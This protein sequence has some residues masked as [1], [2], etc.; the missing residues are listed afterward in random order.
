M[1]LLDFKKLMILLWKNFTLKRRKCMALV[2]EILI[3]VMFGISL[4]G[5]RN[6]IILK[7]T[8]PFNYTAFPVNHKPSFIEAPVTFPYPW[9][10]AYIPSKSAVV[11]NIVENV[12]K[13]LNT[14]MKVVGFSSERDFE[15]Y[16]K[17]SK[18]SEKVLAAIVF[19]H[20][21]QNSN[22]AVPLKVKYYL[23]FSY[24]KKNKSVSQ[25]AGW[26]TN[27]L[28]PLLPLEP[29]DV[30]AADGGRPGYI[31]EGFL[32]VQHAL[33]KAIM[34]YHSGT[35]AE[36]LFN[37]VNIFVQRFPYPL[38]NTDLFFVIAAIIIPVIVAFVFSMNHLTLVQ[39]IVWEKENQLKEFQLMSGLSNWMLWT[40][41]FITFLF[42]YL[43][44]II[45]MCFIFFVKIEPAPVFQYSDPSLIF[46]FLLFYAIAIIFFS[47]M[48]STFFDKRAVFPGKYGMPKPWNFFLMRSYWARKQHATKGE[49][50]QYEKTVQSKYFE[51]EPT[52]L[53]A[54]IQIKH[55]HKV[56]QEN[57]T[58]KVAVKDLSLNLYEGQI[59][60]LL[61][62][63][64]AGKST[65][66]SI[67]SGLYP[68]TSGKAYINGYDISHDMNQIRKSFGVCP[69]KNLLFDYLTVSEHLYFYCMIKGVPHKMCLKEIGHMLSVFKLL[70]KQSAFSKSLSGGMKRKLSIIIA[71]IGGSKVVIVDEPTSGM[72]TASRRATWDLLQNY[73]QGRTILLTTHY[74][75]EADVLGDRIAI[76][77]NG[78]LKCCGSSMFLKHL[79]GVGYH[80]VMVKAPH[81]DV[82]EISKLIHH[83]AP[84]ATLESNV[85]TELSFI[86][87]KEYTDRFEDLFTT[88]ERRQDEL[89]IN[90]FGASVTT[91]EEVFLKVSH[92]ESQTDIQA[93]QSLSQ[94]SKVLT[95]RQNSNMSNNVKR[96]HSL[97]E[98]TT[99]FNTGS[100]RYCQ[101]F[102]AMLLKKLLFS[103]RNWKLIFLQIFG[104]LIPTILLF[105]DSDF[106]IADEE[107]S[108]QMNLDEYGQTIVPYSISGNSTL[109]ISLLKHLESMLAPKNHILREVQG[110]VVNYLRE[111]KECITMCIV[112]LS[113]EVRTN[114][115]IFTALFNNQAYHS[116]SLSLSVLDNI[117]FMSLSGAD[118]SITVY[119]KPQPP[120]KKTKIKQ[121]ERTMNGQE[122]AIKLQ[123]GIALLISGFC[124]LTV[125]ERITKSK[126]I[127][128]LCGVSTLV[129]W[130]SALL[131]DFIIFFI[132]CCLLLGI[133]KYHKIDIYVMDYHF[134]ET[135]LILTLYGWSSI[136]LIYL[137]SFLFSKSTSA[138]IKLVLFNY[139]SGTYSILIEQ[140][141][142]TKME[143][144][145]SNTTQA[146][147]RNMLLLLPNYNL[148]KC[149]SDYTEV[150]RVKILCTQKTVNYLLNCSK[151]N[152]E[153]SIYSLENH[154]IGKCLIAMSILG[155][156]FLIFIFLWENALWRLR[157]FIHQYIYFGIYKKFKKDLMSQ[158]LSGKSEDKDVQDERTRILEQ[159]EELLKSP[160][161]IKELVKIYFK[162]PVILA[163]KN[164]SLAVQKRECFGLLGFNGAGKTTT[165][166]ILT[167]E[168]SPTSGDVFIDGFN[169]TKNNLKVRS[170]IGYCPQFDALLDYMTGKEIITMYARVWGV[171]EHQ[172][173]LYVDKHLKSLE[174]EPH[175]NNLIN[176]YSGGNKRRL[177]TAI[178]VMGKPSVIFLDE[179]STGMD[180]V[181]RRLLWDTVTKTRERGHAVVITSHSMEECEALC[182]KLAI[183]VKGSIMCLGSPQHL[184]NKFGDI[185]I[186][187]AKFKTPDKVPNF[188]N[189]ITMTFP[190]SILKEENQGILTYSIPRKDNSWGK[191]FGILEK[192]KVE[193]SLEDYSIGQITLE[194]VFLTFANPDNAEDD[195]EE[196]VP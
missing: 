169:I 45:F 187:K 32:L 100:S 88:L 113:I 137:M 141:L 78:S 145:M 157:A 31:S 112:A 149:V 89:G 179:P 171:S 120:P 185:Y 176:T 108:R 62:P 103:W 194:Q 8:G 166:E 39:S 173:P 48:V 1:D 191:V 134:L 25:L 90:D 28:F 79:Y 172:I 183:M 42:F 115:T 71:L 105:Q 66:L 41:Y 24:F 106:K 177:N 164:I 148:V 181:A 159:P 35:A 44:D 168:L 13:D 98:N 196:K 82:E 23:R 144:G 123:L 43:F 125:T 73:K 40:A 52:D 18:N 16:L 130:L 87:P 95:M 49:T 85:G 33:D 99:V 76:M 11:Q 7:K 22:D 193:F 119:N 4:L 182:T 5:L 74:M 14:N 170:R 81:C 107:T 152:T 180:P 162:Y 129:Y 9:E 36:T 59:T 116:P 156:V 60:V 174:L 17:Q 188:K 133:F 155:F 160:L 158:E 122:V 64:G 69:Q 139:I 132:S 38:Q 63:N 150:Y 110:D 128:Y 83:Y 20:D 6:I 121:V 109:T 195:F 68:A 117:I 26:F 37:S 151:E 93:T 34:L 127:Q 186:L 138:Y 58:I 147:I 57:N 21:F 91:M 61:G 163:V 126:H 12:K 184:K 94:R 189:F 161:L 50:I 53:V 190:G 175:A 80:I 101:Q 146:L 67:L 29:R 15:N 30:Q 54:G 140:L 46:V 142:K 131:Y 75:D 114:E 72:D 19:D 118:A 10:L 135:M 92:M 3:A 70:E 124:F 167:G 65:T 143:S 192:A 104:L 86:L 56:F 27:S 153:K 55:V 111:N 2:V 154:M 97:N 165:F 96:T 178:A 84:N 51:D 136:P 77:V 47:F 102:H